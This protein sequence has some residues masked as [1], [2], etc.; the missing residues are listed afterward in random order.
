MIAVPYRDCPAL[1]EADLQNH[2]LSSAR[3]DA[4][5]RTDPERRHGTMYYFE[6]VGP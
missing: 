6:H 1:D 3:C 4:K 5:L 2:R